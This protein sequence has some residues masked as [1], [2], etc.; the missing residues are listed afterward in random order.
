M[1]KVMRKMSNNYRDVAKGA[2]GRELAP[3]LRR[4]PCT[5]GLL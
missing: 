2:P 4:W 1:A 3:P 5:H